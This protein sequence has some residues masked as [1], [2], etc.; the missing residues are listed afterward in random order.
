MG[1]MSSRSLLSREKTQKLC[2]SPDQKHTNFGYL[3]ESVYT[4]K[5]PTGYDII[6]WPMGV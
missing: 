2:Y 6:V 5:R 3:L 1:T 4:S